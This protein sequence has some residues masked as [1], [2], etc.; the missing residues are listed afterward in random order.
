MSEP[1]PRL[2][3]DT[4]A[5]LWTIA[6]EL[7]A[8][9]T[10]IVDATDAE[11]GLCVSAIS[12]WEIGML[13]RKPPPRRLVYDGGLGALIAKIRSRSKFVEVPLSIQIAAAVDDLAE[14]LHPD[15]ADRFLV[16]TAQV[17]DIPI[18]TRDRAILAYA[19]TGAVRAIAC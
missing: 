11:A 13:F 2:L 3:L 9:V 19:K 5:L 8:T 14:T 6:G 15:P 10:R 16:A 12:I 18:M 17:L 1:V 7:S 4:H